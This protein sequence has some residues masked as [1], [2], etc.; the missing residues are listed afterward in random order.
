MS[1]ISVYDIVPTPKLADKLIGTSV[2]GVIPD[3]TYNFT[4]E[5]LLQ[6]FIPNIPANNL[7]GV[8]DYGNTATQD[9]N[10]TGTI[11]TTD[12]N[13]F[14]TASILD[15]I[16]SGETHITGELYDG[17]D[18]KGTAGQVL[19]STG[20]GVEW[21]TIPTVIPTLQQVLTS[22]NTADKNIIL[23][24]NIT[25]VT[26]TATNVVSN[27]SLSVNG[28]LKDGTAST[29][30]TDQLLSSTGSGVRWVDMPVY[31]AVSPL[32]YNNT[33]KT[34]S[35]QVA[36][37][38]QGGYLSNA[39]WINFD[40][41]QDA[42]VLTTAGT[43]GA[44]TFVGNT[45]NIPVYSPDL[46]GY[47]PI[48]RTL[49]INGVTYDL[50]AN[51]SWT[52]DAGV[53]E[54]TAT[55]PLSSSG[56]A[57]P[58][59][60]ISQSNSST[61]G[62]LSSAD[63]LDFNS[64]QDGLNGTGL[65]KST[66]GVISYITDNST[67]W[68]TAYNESI[69][70]AEV[71]GTATKTLTLN[72]QD[73]GTIQA[74]W[75]DIDTGLTSVGLSMPSAFTVTNS[76]LTSNGT[77]GVTGAGTTAQYVRGDGSL[78]TFPTIASEAQRLVTEVY[79]NSGA[80]LTKGTV[81]Y[82]NGGQGNLPTITK[83][84]ATGDSTSAQTYGVVQTDITNMNN[85]YVV[86]IGSLQ[87]L[88]T[89]A[90]TNGTQLYLSSTVAGAWTSVKQYAPAHLVYVGIVI[91]SHPTQGVVEIRIQNGFE[92]DELHN[93]FAQNPN[94]NA[95]LQYKTATSLWTS[96][97][98]T[99]SNIAEGTNLYYLDSR[100]RAA[101]SASAPLSYNNITGAFSISQS[102]ASTDG[103][104][105]S[106]D[107]NTFNNKQVAGNYITSLTGEATGTGPGATAV[108]LNNASVTGK[109]LTGV[110]ITGGSVVA[111]DTMLTAFGKL[112]NQI[113]G[114]VGSTIY[115]GV[116]DA[117][118]NTPTL[119][120]SVGTNGFYYI[121]NVAG[122]TN[123]NGI[124]DWK[125]GDWAIFN[126]G[127]WQKVDNTESVTSV[128]G[129]TGAVSLT[130]DNIAQGTTNLYFANSLARTAVSLTTTGSSG[131]A[132]YNNTTGVFNIPNYGSALSGYLPLTG[133]TLTGGLIINP[134]NSATVGLDVA[135]NTFTL[136]TD[137]SQPF[138]RQLTTTLGSGTL[139]KMQAAGYGAVYVTDLG[140]YTSSSS[141]VNTTPNLYL[142][143][144]DNRVGIN[145]I[146][147]AYTLD[148][149]GT[150]G[151]SGVLTLGSTIS[152]G[153][154]T[155]TLPSSTGT[156]ALV[157]GAGVGTVTSV[158]ALTLGTTGTDLS[159]TV[160]NG[161]TT[162]VITLN[163]P[164]ASATNRGALSAADWT[165]F[166]NKQ[167]ALIDPVT[168]T[169]NNNYIAKFTSTGSTIGNSLLQSNASNVFIN[170]ENTSLGVDAQAD[171]RLGFTKKSGFNPYLTYATDP[172]V[173]ASTAGTSIAASNTFTPRL[174]LS[175]AGELSIYNFFNLINAVT[176]G[177]YLDN[178]GRTGG[179]GKSFSILNG[180][181]GAGE[182]SI[183]DE[184]ASLTRFII[185]A[186]GIL[187]IP[188]L[189]GT[190][191][192]IIV[193][194]ASGNLSA[195]SA[196]SGYI[197]GSGTATRL[198]FFDGTSSITSSS[199]L[200]WDNSAGRL[201]VGKNSADARLEVYAGTKGQIR[202]NGGPAM[203]GG[204]DIY[205]ELSGTGRRNWGL[206]TEVQT[207][208]DFSIL[209]SESAG[210]APINEVFTIQ[211]TGIG[212][213]KYDLNVV[214]K[215]G[216][217]DDKGLYLRSTSDVTHKI[218]Y[219]SIGGYNNAIWEYN[220]ALL[221]QYYNAGTPVT[222]AS[223]SID[224]NFWTNGT[225]ETG[226][227]VGIRVTPST[228]SDQYL[229]TGNAGIANSN[230]YFG[231]GSVRIGGNADH[232]ANT[233]FSVAPGVVNF[234]RPGVGGGALK[235]FSDGNIGINQTTNGGRKLEIQ[236]NSTS[237]ALWVQTGGTTSG[238]TIADFRTGTNASALQIFAN[239]TSVFGGEL[240]GTIG[241][242]NSILNVI[243][244]KTGTGIEVHSL[245]N[246]RITGTGAIGDS[247]NIRF[248]NTD[249]VNIANISGILG[250]DNVAYGTLSFQTRNYNTDSMVEVMRL[251]NRGNVEIKKSGIFG[252]DYSSTQY[253]A[254]SENQIYRTGGGTLYI[255]N[256]SSGAVAIAQ[257][258]GNIGL[259][260]LGNGTGTGIEFASSGSNPRFNWLVGGTYTGEINSTSS[261]LRIKTNANLPIYF[262]VNNTTESFQITKEGYI[263]LSTVS[264]IP[265]T[266]NT[267]LSYSPNGYMYIMGGS[268]GIGITASGNR[269]NAIYLNNT[270]N[271]ILFQTNNVGTRMTLNGAGNLA[272]GD[273]NTPASYARFNLFDTG[274]LITGGTATAGTNMKGIF[275]ENTLNGDESI[276]VWFRTG[277]NHLSGIS[278]QRDDN[279][280]GWGTDLR[281]Y[282][283]ERNTADLSSTRERVRITSEGNVLVGTTI[284][285]FSAAGRGNV[286]I[287]GS[288]ASMLGLTVGGVSRGY[289]FHDDVTMYLWNTKVGS[290]I[291][292]TSSSNGVYLPS[293]GTA[294][295]STSDEKTKT[296]LIP[297]TDAVN[298]V[299]SLRAV[300]GRYK[301][302][303]QGT[304]RAFLIAQDVQKVLPEAVNLNNGVLGLSYTEVIPL[305]VASV[306]EED[307]KIVTL[308]NKVAEL[309]AEI[310]TLKN[311]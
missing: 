243:K 265:T 186:T 263:Q 173:I 55:A 310:I 303:T 246:L 234:D 98:G 154:F 66:A 112:Q 48:S 306:K 282:T 121:V 210:T 149:V 277:S 136:R 198:A 197:T 308:Q 300:T 51:R 49:T 5:E 140:F 241:T 139:V 224:G 214:G 123:L 232:A 200:Y 206:Y 27:S 211:S 254:I 67:N 240:S 189:A 70:S 113:N 311:K 25:A 304:S 6:L 181:T 184:T 81:V 62:Y 91:R 260:I 230:T 73:G 144:G 285:T 166:N 252:L 221:F 85:G 68:N 150:A 104:L 86:V 2:G 120:S 8:L 87:N 117:S 10:L 60:S 52:V 205:T 170:Q 83:A 31:N 77:I 259:G 11:N 63:W 227:N 273:A 286:T 192:R 72:Q 188:N 131:N 37:S 50:S 47:V 242:F 292:V 96:V 298:K 132:T 182:F 167:N 36:N 163:V 229:T 233:V 302:D 61:D 202:A 250:A 71:T 45:L 74:S 220:S 175:I 185:G 148:V 3:V 124:T 203:G 236:T 92:M 231:T 269:E 266:N 272:L 26:A 255:N 235:I 278:G 118:T 17:L 168:G 169:G 143:G 247:I 12:L 264:T 209:V 307:A 190:G 46:S 283:H 29:G 14:A 32:L 18:S 69:I 107:W 129:F 53:A 142:T 39:D 296:D 215:F 42:I 281:F 212:S 258:G 133:G 297:I 30:S 248:A 43:S 101:L 191:S 41:K 54:V 155:Y 289:L 20:S 58:D 34:F 251:N 1:E 13:V 130:T 145:T 21:Y 284:N 97:D 79:N 301:T 239:S 161:T 172:L 99:T 110:N 217:A 88:D 93:V 7:Q 238:Y 288:S 9:I 165:T 153:T 268:T 75:S 225:I 126:G 218:Y 183:K 174:Q 138:N 80:T 158:A 89:Q 23:T 305:L 65:V 125:I 245:L 100:A 94:N 38:S 207:A 164:T 33:T 180:N 28:S 299:V 291:Q 59:I 223:L 135:S 261:L 244:P 146:T 160:A 287:N 119:T 111:T 156:L 103:Y 294:W 152:N 257:G 44:A 90:Y 64:K 116:W 213:Y 187:N 109:V 171:T 56:G 276:G 249:N 176:P 177:I 199:G 222:K 159:S 270:I 226:G 35:I 271:S 195:S 228:A 76:P 84:I 95:I 219:K 295:L 309:E 157:G 141:A 279:T 262:T 194:D 82:V 128:N 237:A 105:S 147:P 22:G 4:L 108:T 293:G 24:A 201:A 137:T 106:T 178:T 114:L 275:V 151:V 102:G 196:L 179:A 274:S 256:S 15:S 115:Q 253:I 208:G 16:L 40:G 280:L 290:S 134:A 127:V 122:S 162:P 19:T 267:I 216:V 204:L 57:Y 78:A 193:A